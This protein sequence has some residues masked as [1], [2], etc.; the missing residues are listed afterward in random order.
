MATTTGDNPNDDREKKN[1]SSESCINAAEAE[2]LLSLLAL[3][4]GAMPWPKRSLRWQHSNAQ[5]SINNTLSSLPL[6]SI[7]NL[8][9]EAAQWPGAS[10]VR[11]AAADLATASLFGAT[12]GRPSGNLLATVV[13]SSSFSKTSTAAVQFAML[14]S[15]ACVA[16]FDFIRKLARISAAV[17]PEICLPASTAPSSLKAGTEQPTSSNDT[18]A[19]SAATSGAGSFSTT[20]AVA[21]PS[22]TVEEEGLLLCQD[23]IL[24]EVLVHALVLHMSSSSSSSFSTSSSMLPE[25]VA[26]GEL[27]RFELGRTL[28]PDWSSDDALEGISGRKQA[29]LWGQVARSLNSD[30]SFEVMQTSMR[31]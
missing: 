30:Q 31:Q 16:G 3:Q 8:V 23:A 13:D 15:D 18:A 22:S 12:A 17:R 6:P 27:L 9:L 19:N 20:A 4:L 11:Q 21:A 1:N 7:E 14:E 29:G 10:S 25:N 24:S 5:A 28:W 26:S 2:G